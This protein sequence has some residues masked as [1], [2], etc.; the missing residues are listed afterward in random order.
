MMG[1]VLLSSYTELMH[2]RKKSTWDRRIG[3]RVGCYGITISY[4]QDFNGSYGGND[5]GNWVKREVLAY[6]YLIYTGARELFHQIS[7]AECSFNLEGVV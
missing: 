3:L 5:F 2:G 1:E 6:G 4:L 7:A